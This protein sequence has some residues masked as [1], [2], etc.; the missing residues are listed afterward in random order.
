MEDAEK[1]VIDS[2]IVVDD[3]LLLEDGKEEKGEK[4]EKGDLCVRKV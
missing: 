2:M 4:G 3:A 1:T